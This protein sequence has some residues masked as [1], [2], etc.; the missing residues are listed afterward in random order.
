MTEPVVIR[1]GT[2]VDGSGAPGR[3]ADVVI[4]NGRIRA[5]GRRRPPR[6]APAGD[7]ARQVVAPRVKDK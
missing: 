5:V 3:I 4:E 1:R 7:P 6:G 2:V